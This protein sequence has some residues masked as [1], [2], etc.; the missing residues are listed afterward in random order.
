[1]ASRGVRIVASV[2]AACVL[3]GFGYGWYN[4]R[5][6][7]SGLQRLTL[8]NLAGPTP[9]G[10]TSS[11]SAPAGRTH[12]GT[13]QNILLV[14]I[15]SRAGLSAAQRRTY[16]TGDDSSMSTDTMMIM[17]V[18]A[19]GSSATLISLPRDSYVEIP[20]YLKNKLNAAY[21]DGYT[22]GGGGTDEQRTAAGADL[23][24]ATVTK[25]TGLRITHYVQVGFLG[26][27][28]IVRAIGKIPVT[29]CRS[30]D[31]TVAYNRA[32]GQTGGSG[33]VM[34]AG[35]H[36]LGPVQALEFVRQR[37]NLHGGDLARVARQQ[38]FLSAAFAKI[39]SMNVLLN[40]GKLHS[41]IKAITGSFYIDSTSSIESLAG[42]LANLSAG[43]IVGHTIP[44]TGFATVP[45]VGSV[46]VVDPIQVREFVTNL[47]N[48]RP[49]HGSAKPGAGA[50][51]ATP[52]AG[53]TSSGATSSA[54]HERSC[55][56]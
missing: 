56:E 12:A 49:H 13:E 38:Y 21:A 52:G 8:H 45:N 30:V 51:A 9:A 7:D 44:H 24:I 18:P 37:H 50:P 39:S 47:I 26:F 15:D 27:A 46:E 6:L 48:P 17:H 36:E 28:N 25:L 54:P 35:H 2:R 41:L 14:G 11:R 34:S 43:K 33:F 22:Y 31:D 1:V 4:Y 55:I 23:L 5:T 40:P 3:L 32:H 19:D 10:P 29:L 16:H 53:R 20:G 42:Q